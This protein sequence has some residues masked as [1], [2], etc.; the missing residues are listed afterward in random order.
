[1]RSLLLTACA[2]HAACATLLL[3]PQLADLP[4]NQLPMLQAHDTGTSYLRAS[5]A[6]TDVLYRFTRTQDA[7]N[8]TMLLDCGARSFDWRPSLTG[9]VLGFAHGPVFINHSM[10]AAAAEVVAWAGAH[11]AQAED[12]LVLLNVADC[13]SDACNAEALAAFARVG[14]P[15]V[16]GQGCVAASDYTL[17]AAMAAAALP[18]G[19]HALA[20]LNCPGAPT[21]TYDDRRSCTG[22]FNV[23]QG[24]AFEA[25]VAACLAAPSAAEALACIEAAAGLADLPDHYACYTDGSGRNAS[26]PLQRLQEWV[27]ATASV[28]PPSAPGQ[29]GLLVSLQGCWAQNVQSTILSFLHGSSLL[30]DESRAEFNSAPLLAWLPQLQHVNQVGLNAVCDNGPALLAALRKRLPPVAAAPPA[31]AL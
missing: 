23:T 24:E 31:G 7:D 14:L 17:G 28:A 1:M 9:G 4:L 26:W 3:R 30:L 29:R 8:V 16:A 18:G 25:E 11:A 27:F 21:D 12:A 5:S 6:I 15:A 2:A 20:L 22:F 10:E 19:G 13:N